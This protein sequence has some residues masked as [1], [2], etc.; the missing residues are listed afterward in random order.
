MVCT[1]AGRAAGSPGSQFDS[2]VS[3]IR[4]EQVRIHGGA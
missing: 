2:G 4:Q 3:P 1:R